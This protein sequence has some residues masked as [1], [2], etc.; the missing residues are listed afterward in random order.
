MNPKWSIDQPRHDLRIVRLEQFELKDEPA[1]IAEEL[2]LAIDEL[3]LEE[4]A[5]RTVEVDFS[6]W[7]EV[8]SRI[9][10]FLL[11]FHRR[12]RDRG[13]KLIVSSPPRQL[14][15]MATRVGV[16]VELGLGISRRHDY[17]QLFLHESRE[18]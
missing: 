10:A 8:N 4:S 14:V 5:E 16:S 7:H 15:E 2:S 3:F 9:F 1:K 13:N 6:K 18:S 12:C 17:R 11:Q